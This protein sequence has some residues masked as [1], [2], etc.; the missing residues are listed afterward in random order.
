MET[1]KILNKKFIESIKIYKNSENIYIIHVK[2]NIKFLWINKKIDYY[3]YF[4][5]IYDS[6][7]ELKKILKETQ[8]YI[9][10]TTGKIMYYPHVTLR[11]VSGFEHTLYFKTYEDILLF[12]K[13]TLNINTDIIINNNDNDKNYFKINCIVI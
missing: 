5:S 1:I 2:K 10:E 7:D 3:V 9:D 6:K 4:G 11:Y 12:L 13:N 8:S